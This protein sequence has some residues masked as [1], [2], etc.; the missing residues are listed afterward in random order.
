[1]FI[2][3]SIGIAFSTA[4][5]EYPE[6]ILRD[7][8]TAMYRAKANGKARHEIFDQAMHTR[9]M[10]RL[11]LENDLRHAIERHELHVY[12]QPI[13]HLAGNRVSGFEALVRWH[14]P[15]R[16]LISPADFIPLAEETGLIIPL[17][18]DV[19]R[20]ACRQTVAWHRQF[21]SAQP[22]T[23]SVNLSPKQ[24]K[25]P[26]LV[27]QVRDILEETQ[28][29]PHCLRLEITESLVMENAEFAAQVMR[30]LKNTGIRLSL[31]DFGTGYS[32]LSHLH[33]FPFDILKVDKSFVMSLGENKGSEKIVKTILLLAAELE[34]AAVAEG[35]ETEQQAALLTALDCDY[36]QGYL[37]AKPLPAEA[38]ERMLQKN[39]TRADEAMA[40]ELFMLEKAETLSSAYPM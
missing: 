10:E 9:A 36:G 29:P 26:D 24:L 8:D 23:I 14:H 40:E 31:D 37:Y 17:G 6:D 12:Y 2:S 15:Q 35:V 21:P 5:Y 19:L 4:G 16:G 3:G 38:I 13:T 22:F 39:S 11:Q 28:I 27:E 32:S 33:R 18:L 25:Q 34:M 7:S 30:H 1:V 20:Q